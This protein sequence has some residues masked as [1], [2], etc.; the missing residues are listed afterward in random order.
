[1]TASSQNDPSQK[2]GEQSAPEQAGAA[3]SNP[4]PGPDDQDALARAPEIVDRFGGIR[5]MASKMRIPV[6]TVQGWKKRGVIP[7]NRRGDVLR[8]ARDYQVDLSG[9]LGGSPGAACVAAS[10]AASSPSPSY[11]APGAPA[12][13]SFRAEMRAA[14]AGAQTSAQAGTTQAGAQAANQPSAPSGPA[15]AGQDALLGRIAASHRSAVRKSVMISTI[16]ILAVGVIAVLLLAPGQQRIE[17]QVQANGKRI[18][19]LETRVSAGEARG[20][21]ALLSQALQNRLE[22]LKGQAAKLKQNIE[23]TGSVVESVAGPEGGSLAQRVGAL[24]TKL[25]ALTAPVLS[26][27]APTGTALP[28]PVA[29]NGLASLTGL[30]GRLKGLEQDAA[31]QAQL[32]AAIRQM[33][34][35]LGGGTAEDGGDAADAL[36]AAPAGS[37][38]GQTLQGVG[39]DDV[40][41]AAMLVALAQFRAQ[42]NGFSTRSPATTIPS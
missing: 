9:L 19:A 14:Q 28:A 36:A 27:V 10:A 6:T 4:C 20:K 17:Q 2:D 29:T 38:L 3:A 40:K 13:N 37:P 31:G 32:G 33:E 16:I 21:L 39:K 42:M 41:A 25:S 24:E 5:P 8:A 34:T 23:G 7:G 15:P 30:L 26:G 22:Q 11:S 35:L 1:M 18:A 12:P